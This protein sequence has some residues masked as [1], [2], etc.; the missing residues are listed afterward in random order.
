MRLRARARRVRETKGGQ[1]AP[2][3][4]GIVVCA[5]W[6]ERLRAA[7]E[8]A[9]RERERAEAER[10]VKD[11]AKRWRVML[12]AVWTRLSLREEFEG[13]DVGDEIG[14]DGDERPR[15]ARRSRRASPGGVPVPDVT[16]TG[17][18]GMMSVVAGGA[19]AEVE[20]KFGRG[21]PLAKDLRVGTSRRRDGVDRSRRGRPSKEDSI[22]PP[23][24][25]AGAAGRVWSFVVGG[26]NACTM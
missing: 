20:E 18:S 12:S 1:C 9:E 19:V 3:F 17:G 5:E 24:T 22:D 14:G 6:E 2:K 21:T 13:I 8:A 23:R 4:E 15:D 7:W 26:K 11:A 25:A 16:F 10:R